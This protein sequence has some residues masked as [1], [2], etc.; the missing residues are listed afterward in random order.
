M[1]PETGKRR[2]WSKWG[3]GGQEADR[4]GIQEKCGSVRRG[5]RICEIAISCSG[6]TEEQGKKIIWKDVASVIW[7]IA[8]Y[9]TWHR[10]L[11][12]RASDFTLPAGLCPRRGRAPACLPVAASRND[13]GFPA[14]IKTFPLQLFFQFS[15]P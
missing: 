14:G 9:N 2:F 4:K 8:E 10:I 7:A 11:G 12:I 6:R 3:T 13:P 15:A 5:Y 1:Q